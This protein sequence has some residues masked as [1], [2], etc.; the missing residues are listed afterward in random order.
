MRN[1]Q[2]LTVARPQSEKIKF[3]KASLILTLTGR[4]DGAKYK[5]RLSEAELDLLEALRLFE[6]MKNHPEVPWLYD[7]AKK[8]LNLLKRINEVLFANHRIHE[9]AR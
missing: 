9:D 5:D 4:P 1:N 2:G 8:S 7:E 6:M 3:F